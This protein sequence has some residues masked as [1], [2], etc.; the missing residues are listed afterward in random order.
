MTSH[1]NYILQNRKKST[2]IL[3]FLSGLMMFFA[4]SISPLF[5]QKIIDVGIKQGDLR[6]FIYSSIIMIIVGT[7][8]HLLML[9]VSLMTVSLKNIQTKNLSLKLFKTYF[10]SLFEKINN[11]D[12]GTHSSL[13]YDEVSCAVSLTIDSIL[14]VSNSLIALITS[15]VICLYFSW[16]VTLMLLI[17][18]PVL[19]VLSSFFSKK[20]TENSISEKE[21]ESAVRGTLQYNLSAYKSVNVYGLHDEVSKSYNTKISFFF[22]NLFRRVKIE[23]WF[24]TLSGIIGSYQELA[25]VLVTGYEVINGTMTIGE[26][27]AYSRTFYGIIGYFNAVSKYL[28]QFSKLKGYVA[29]LKD[30][31][32]NISSSNN[33]KMQKSDSASY[34]IR[35]LN[36]SFENNS[37]IN[38]FQNKSFSFKKGESHLI[39]GS[40]G[41]GKTTLMNLLV[42]FLEPIEGEIYG[43]PIDNVSITYSQVNFIQGTLKDNIRYSDLTHEKQNLYINLMKLFGLEDEIDGTVDNLSTGQ[44]QKV[45]IIQALLKDSELYIFDEPTANLDSNI[46]NVVMD[47]I[48]NLTKDKTL[49]C[50]I[51]NSDGYQ[52][53]FSNVIYLEGVKMF[54]VN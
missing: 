30:Y 23:S 40:N 20:I 28:P 12:I 18:I 9:K 24:N 5:L 6:F 11:R 3:I 54:F 49:I 34:E 15:F 17:I 53:M 51:H 38:I 31:E 52:S 25:I 42:G 26:F 4:T 39:L 47:T 50:I 45:T 10:R 29:R 22:E 32:S 41:C 46:S 48:F 19:L 7:L 21:S 2:L 44:K 43:E 35:A 16:K 14:G 27:F 36:F 37:N 33:S 8:L 13:I 1:I